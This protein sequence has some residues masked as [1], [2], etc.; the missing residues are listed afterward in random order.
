MKILV[1]DVGGTH[2]KVLAS[3]HK[4]PI[5]ILSGPDMTAKKMVPPVR[6]ATASWNHDAVSIG[7]PG[8]VLH[9][10][11]QETA[12]WRAVGDNTNAF[13]GGFHLGQEPAGARGRAYD[14]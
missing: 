13:R 12:A 9:C 1:I 5:E 7:Y 11:P 4:K 3:G 2:V 8:P 14:R 10:R 6:Q